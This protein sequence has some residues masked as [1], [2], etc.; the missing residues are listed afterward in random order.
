VEHAKLGSMFAF[1]EAANC[2]RQALLGYFGEHIEPCGNC[3]NCINPVDTWDGTE[4]A[5]KALSN[6]FR[7]DQR[8]GVNHLTQVLVGKETDSLRRF[9]HHHVS[10]FGIGRELSQ[11]QWKS[12][13]RQLLAGGYCTV[14]PERFNA[15]TLN[16]RSWPVLKGEKQVR[17]RTDPVR[18]KM[19]TKSKATRMAAEDVLTN[20]ETEKLFDRLRD[21]RLS[22]AE[23]Q[24]V[25]PYAIFPDKTLLELVKYRPQTLQQ[26]GCISGVGEV[27]LERFGDVFLNA[28]ENHAD[29]H[30]R[31]AN[32]L[33]IP[34]DRAERL[35]KQKQKKKEFPGTA[36]ESLELFLEFGT[37]DDVAERRSLKPST[38]WQ[39]LALAAELGKID[40]RR[41]C[42]LPDV[43][44]DLI[45]STLTAFREKGLIALTPVFEALEGKYPYNV[46]RLVRSCSK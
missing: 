39:H 44:I 40:Y 7:T 11:E 31:P 37:V 25:P 12:V 15:L 14:D 27:K 42:A 30:G 8:V 10:T 21:L 20:W 19:K 16:E 3:D 35:E 36:K 26:L 22:I 28:M 6:I 1:L 41:V 32:L 13:Y 38:I 9:G 18:T 45:R 23:E 24:S 5:Q 46:I 33:P 34:E 17:F 2:R 43:E 4:A 29:E